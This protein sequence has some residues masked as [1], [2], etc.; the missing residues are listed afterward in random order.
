MT[1]PTA[2]ITYSWDDEEHKS[3]VKDLATKL[4]KDGV[5]VVVDIWAV[6]LGRQ[7]PEFMERGI[8]DS[9]FVL[10]ICTPGYRERSDGRRGGVGYEGHIITSEIFARGNH[11][12]FIPIL[13]RGTWGDGEPTDAAA[14]WIRGKRYIDLAGDPYSEANYRELV[15]T[16]FGQRETAPPLGE[17]MVVAPENPA[18]RQEAELFDGQ[19]PHHRP[20]T[21]RL[22]ALESELKWSISACKESFIALGVNADIAAELANDADVGRVLEVPEPG[23]HLLLGDQGSGKSLASRRLFQRAVTDVI[24]DPS[25]PFPIFFEAR[26]IREPVRRLIA[27]R[28]LGNVDPHQQPAL[29]VVDGIDEM[30]SKD[31]TRLLRDLEIYADANPK[32]RILTT[33]RPLP[34]LHRPP[35]IVKI[36][37]LDTDQAAQLI[38]RVAGDDMG[39]LNLARWRHSVREAAKLPLFAIMIGAW[40]CRHSGHVRLSGYA[41]VEDVA[42][43]ALREST[44]NSEDADRLLQLL[45]VGTISCGGN[46]RPHEVT[47]V[48]AQQHILNDSRLVR[49]IRGT[50]DFALPIFREWYAARAILEGTVSLADIDLTSDRWGIPL[51]IVAHSDDDAMA[52]A[53]MEALAL[54][55]LGMASMVLKDNAPTT[56]SDDFGP[57]LPSDATAIGEEIRRAMEVWQVALGPLFNALGPIDP[58]GKVPALGVCLD[59]DHLITGWYQGVDPVEPVVEFPAVRNPFR[60]HGTREEARDWPVWTGRLGIPENGLW[61]WILTKDELV[62]RLKE[63][64]DGQQLAYVA[65]EAVQEL[66][67]EFALDNIRRGSRHQGPIPVQAALDKVNTLLSYGAS[68]L[69]PIGRRQY[70]RDE[71]IAVR[72]HLD[73]LLQQGEEELFEPWPAADLRLSSP[74]IW[75]RYSDERL[76]DRVT[77]IYSAALRIY[78]AMVNSWFSSFTGLRLSSLLPVRIEGTLTTYDERY[79]VPMPSLS[80]YP[81]ILPTGE[82]SRVEFQLGP[83]NASQDDAYRYFKDQGSAFAGL[84]GGN[85]ERAPLFYIFFEML[86]DSSSRPATELAHKWL[87]EDLKRLG[88]LDP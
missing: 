28:C 36:P 65:Q 63:A 20:G 70:S 88:W 52:R 78:E 62:E 35:S 15:S 69:F 31:A 14:A 48:A 22:A 26:E 30:G 68:L 3:W 43:E 59:H 75:S 81:T 23:L 47:R 1:T 86:K 57:S 11:D 32:V 24:D 54:T 84:R 49:E 34:G 5:N 85:P 67:W 64:M 66:V 19:A 60:H 74:S 33:A 56:S 80:W 45:G 17:P 9:D 44:A 37:E 12:K 53:S 40:L 50:I 39:P 76:L 7:L 25:L 58:A 82:E 10:I 2:F 77:R 87:G 61:S 51:S 42:R 79:D 73:D 16:L 4:R 21:S 55:N 13:R 27:E 46:V 71:M 72:D 8:T 29:V 6:A 18:E 41:L 83:S 38:Q